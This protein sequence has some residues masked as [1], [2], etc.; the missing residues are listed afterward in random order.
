MKIEGAIQGSGV[1]ID[2]GG[3]TYKVLSAWHVIGANKPG[4]EVDIITSDDNVHSAIF[5]IKKES[6]A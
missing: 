5:L 1:I 2:R 4:E 6:E 3:S